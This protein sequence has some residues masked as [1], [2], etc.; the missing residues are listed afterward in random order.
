MMSQGFQHA[1]HMIPDQK[2]LVG[3][4]G[5]IIPSFLHQRVDV[6]L[7]F[8]DVLRHLLVREARCHGGNVIAAVQELYH[9]R[10]PVPGDAVIVRSLIFI[11]L[12]EVFRLSQ[13][14][15]RFF[16]RLTHREFFRLNSAVL[17]HVMQKTCGEEIIVLQT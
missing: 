14:T 12:F 11:R 3:I 17:T 8:D 7:R 10:D 4:L 1:V 13:K 2:Q 5:I 16:C 6:F 9:R 15:D